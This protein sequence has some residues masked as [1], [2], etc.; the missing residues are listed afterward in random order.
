M[1]GETLFDFM[2]C[3]GIVI[4]FPTFALSILAEWSRKKPS[5]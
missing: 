3:L 2:V 5:Q 1:S 4:A